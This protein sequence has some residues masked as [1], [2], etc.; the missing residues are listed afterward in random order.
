MIQR[1]S[2]LSVLERV[3]FATLVIVLVGMVVLDVMRPRRFEADMIGSTL[4]HVPIYAMLLV[5]SVLV[6]RRAGGIWFPSLLIVGCVGM[7]GLLLVD[8][9]EFVRVLEELRGVPPDSSMLRPFLRRAL[10]EGMVLLGFGFLAA[11]LLAR[12]IK[13]K[14]EPGATDNPDDAQ[15]IRE[16]H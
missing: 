1:Y 3:L 10:P 12:R 15:R 11:L 9:R 16:D 8:Y 14:A 2:L 5:S 6:A 7:L 4:A 13:D